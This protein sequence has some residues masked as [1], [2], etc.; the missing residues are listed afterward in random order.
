MSE[1]LSIIRRILNDI[2]CNEDKIKTNEYTYKYLN[3][4]NPLNA[5]VEISK[6]LFSCKYLNK[7]IVW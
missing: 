6:M 7:Q 2:N 4:A 1:C 3:D 5:F